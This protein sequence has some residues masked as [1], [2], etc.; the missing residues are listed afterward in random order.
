MSNYQQPGVFVE[1]ISTMADPIEGVGTSTVAFIGRAPQGPVLEPVLV[2]SWGEFERTFGG[3]DFSDTGNYLAHAVSLFFQ[4][5]GRRAYVVR[6]PKDPEAGTSGSGCRSGLESI[7]SLEDVSIVAMPDSTGVLDQQA[8]IEHC[9]RMRYRFAVLD[10]PPDPHEVGD[11]HDVRL[12]RQKLE[13]AKGYAAI[14]YPWLQVQ[15]P[16]TK[17]IRTVPPCGA[18][19]GIFA[20]TDMQKGVQKAPANELVKGILGIE[21]AVDQR[22]QEELDRI[23][24]NVIRK[25]TGRGYLVWGAKTV[26][27]DSLWKY[28]PVRRTVIYLEQSIS[29]GTEWAAYEPHDEKTWARVQIPIVS[30]LTSS[31]KNGLLLGMKPEEAFLVRCDRTT[32]TQKD[33]DEGNLIVE[34]GVALVRPAEFVIFRI[35]QKMEKVGP[36]SLI[37]GKLDPMKKKKHWYSSPPKK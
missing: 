18:V 23:N 6:A 20:R 25:F 31:W 4:N 2:T 1:E 8:M 29:I 13:S 3:L 10:S 30:F 37:E 34:V 12:L 5:D 24:V 19:A 35:G 28:V 17:M 32:M 9:E 7:E 27:S 14:Y 21:V 16:G 36:R 11:S 26:S 22:D 15:D 33:I